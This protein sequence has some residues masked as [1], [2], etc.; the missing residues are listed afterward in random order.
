MEIELF[1]RI[2]NLEN[3]LID[4]L[5]PQLTGGEYE[6]LVRGF[7]DNTLTIEHYCNTIINELF[8]ITVMEF[9]ANLVEQLFDLLVSEPSDHHEHRATCPPPD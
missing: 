3:R 9:K 2:R 7:L 5:P 8:E 6:A 4:G 1:A